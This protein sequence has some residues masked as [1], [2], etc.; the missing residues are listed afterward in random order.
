[1]PVRSGN[2]SLYYKTDGRA[3]AQTLLEIPGVELL[4][5]VRRRSE[6]RDTPDAGA[7]H[8]RET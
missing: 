5:R 7:N 4:T 6:R 1:V 3:I 2:V 8:G